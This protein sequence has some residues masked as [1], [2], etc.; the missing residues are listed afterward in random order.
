[1]SQHANKNQKNNIKKQHKKNFIETLN[2]V[3][4]QEISC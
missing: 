1:M 3:K 4:I 2:L